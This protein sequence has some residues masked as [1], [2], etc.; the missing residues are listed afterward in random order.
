MKKIL[1]EIHDLERRVAKSSAPKSLE[2]S[3]RRLEWR[4]AYVG[5]YQRLLNI[6][7]SDTAQN[8]ATRRCFGRFSL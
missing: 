7:T 6:R 3:M 1:A 4:G 5:G 2:V 8:S